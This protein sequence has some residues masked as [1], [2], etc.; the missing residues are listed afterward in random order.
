MQ[1]N[2][3]KGF[4]KKNSV[5]KGD[6]LAGAVNQGGV[7]RDMPRSPR[8]Y[9]TYRI[10]GPYRQSVETEAAR[11]SSDARRAIEDMDHRSASAETEAQIA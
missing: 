4:V 6:F 11:R 10:Y 1:Y 8:T 2:W 3:E 5:K 9:R 7:T